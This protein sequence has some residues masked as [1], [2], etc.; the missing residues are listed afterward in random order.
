MLLLH[1][2][3]M[4]LLWNL[5]DAKYL[6]SPHSESRAL[7]TLCSSTAEGDSFQL[8]CCRSLYLLQHEL[9]MVMGTDGCGALSLTSCGVINALEQAG[10][11]THS[12]SETHSSREK[13]RG[14]SVAFRGLSRGYVQVR[15]L[16]FH[17]HLQFSLLCLSRSSLKA[18]RNI[19]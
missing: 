12:Q 2:A 3:V 5:T 6:K 19:N 8:C 14:E 17:L 13:R 1:H 16:S 9:T 10:A 15:V 18:Q 7:N 4:V 11:L